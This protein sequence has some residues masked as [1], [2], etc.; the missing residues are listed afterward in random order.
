V[1]SVVR[2]ALAWPF[3]AYSV[4]LAKSSYAPANPPEWIAKL[5]PQV[6]LLSVTAGDREGRPSPEMLEVLKDYTL[7]R[8]DRNEWIELAMDGE[9]MW[10]DVERK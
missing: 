4:R 9:Q 3:A 6:V 2:V 1:A 5:H 10:V 8:T 7:L